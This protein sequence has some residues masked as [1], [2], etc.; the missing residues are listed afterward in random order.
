MSENVSPQVPLRLLLKVEGIACAVRDGKKI[1][2]A[3]QTL[4]CVLS[5][6]LLFPSRCIVL[7]SDGSA[8]LSSFE[9]SALKCIQLL[10]YAAA[11][12]APTWSAVSSPMSTAS[13]PLGPSQPC[14]ITIPPS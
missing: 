6:T 4:P 9:S 11:A 3:L 5:A 7:Q 13:P 12:R 1:V 10:G 2:A 8:D 14:F